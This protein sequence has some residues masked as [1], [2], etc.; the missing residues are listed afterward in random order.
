M[1]SLN[2]YPI[3]GILFLDPTDVK[4]VQWLRYKPHTLQRR[5]NCYS[6]LLQQVRNEIIPRKLQPNLFARK[7]SEK[8]RNNNKK[9]KGTK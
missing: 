6:N 8:F 1:T 4:A 7:V 5:A 9:V 3:Q 2:G